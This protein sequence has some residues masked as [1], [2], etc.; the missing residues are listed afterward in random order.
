MKVRLFAILLVGVFLGLTY[1]N[2]HQ[3]NV[4][5][6]YSF[7]I[8][9]FGPVCVVGGLF[10]LFFPTKV[11]RPETGKDKI[12]VLLVFGI[13]LLAG[14]CNLYLMDPSFFGR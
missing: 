11:G 2:W 1:Y 4:E 8:A 3:L 9:T 14:L 10:L 13:G 6:R 7:K 12:I 5:G